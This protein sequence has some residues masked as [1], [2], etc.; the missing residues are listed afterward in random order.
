MSVANV[1]SIPSANRQDLTEEQLRE[2]IQPEVSRDS[3]Q[4]SGKTFRLRVLPWKW[5][6]AFRNKVM[7]LL[8]TEMKPF[9]KIIYFFSTELS[10]IKE[11]AQ[12]TEAA[13]G[14]ELNADVHLTD[15]VAI[16]CMSQDE[17]VQQ[18]AKEGIEMPLD[19]EMA[20]EKKYRL[21][22]QNAEMESSPRIFL[23]NVVRQQMQKQKLVETLGESLM[24][25]LDEFAKMTGTTQTFDSVKRAFTKQVSDYLARIGQPASTSEK[26]S[27]PST[28][29]SS[30]TSSRTPT[31]QEP[32]D[33]AAAATAGA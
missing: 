13:I 15:A 11:D 27:L 4:I 28:E 19:Q 6:Q 7:P 24:V 33:A 23:R 14:S 26:S 25:R 18:A 16:I 8:A 22:I 2:V 5:E 21:M 1:T 31:N 20:I 32:L 3:F 17:A 9:E 29:S 30:E 12:F 10:L